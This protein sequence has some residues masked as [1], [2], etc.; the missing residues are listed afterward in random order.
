MIAHR[1]STIQNA[2]QIAVVKAGKV[3]EVGT[4]S[5]LLQK[6]GIYYRLNR[7]QLFRKEAV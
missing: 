6:K 2:D 3:E 5:V 7:A 1:L 4:H